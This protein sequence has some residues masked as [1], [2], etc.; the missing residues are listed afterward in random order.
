MGKEITLF[1]ITV[2][3]LTKIPIHQCVISRRCLPIRSDSVGYG[4]T[5]DMEY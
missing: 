2:H 5:N 4:Y 3:P 1:E